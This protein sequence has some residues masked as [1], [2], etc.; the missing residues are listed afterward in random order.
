MLLKITSMGLLTKKIVFVLMLSMML[1]PLY[2]AYDVTPRKR[3][4]I[5]FE[6]KATGNIFPET[7]RCQGVKLDYPGVSLQFTDKHNR[8]YVR[9]ARGHFFNLHSSNFVPGAIEF[10]AGEGIKLVKLVPQHAVVRKVKLLPVTDEN[11]LAVPLD[12]RVSGQVRDFYLTPGKNGDAIYDVCSGKIYGD[13]LPVEGG[14]RYR[15]T[16]NGYAGVSRALRIGVEFYNHDRGGRASTVKSSRT[17][18]QI[19]GKQTQCVYIFRTPEKA[20]W[21]RATMR[22]GF[23]KS[24]KIEKI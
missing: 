3:Y 17:Q 19:N 16:V 10:Y 6:A 11:N 20:R 1:L 23:V 22:W 4:R 9:M 24:Y 14:Q 8:K 5:E 7:F 13:P 18:I 12:Y 2:G 21:M 15:L